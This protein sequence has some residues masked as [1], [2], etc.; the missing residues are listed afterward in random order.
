MNEN[1][2]EHCKRSLEPCLNWKEYRP[3]ENGSSEFPIDDITA[4]AIEENERYYKRLEC[5]RG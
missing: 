4:E 3:F 2:I 1:N 5:F